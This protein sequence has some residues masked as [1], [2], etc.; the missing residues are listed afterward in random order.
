[1]RR[2]SE[3]MNTMRPPIM[4]SHMLFESPRNVSPEPPEAVLTVIVL[5]LV[6]VWEGVDESVTFSVTVKECALE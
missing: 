4:I 2:V 1:V 5:E 6:A 3:A